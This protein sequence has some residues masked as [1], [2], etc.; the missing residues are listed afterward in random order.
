MLQTIEGIIDKQGHIQLLEPLMFT[1]A[2]RVL[3]TILEDSWIIDH[4]K[5]PLK[6]SIVFEKDIVAPLDISWEVEK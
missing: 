4:N 2:R 5:N 1:T 3:V 6:N